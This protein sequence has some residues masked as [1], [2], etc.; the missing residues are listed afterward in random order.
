MINIKLAPS[1]LLL[2]IG[3]KEAQIY[4]LSKDKDEAIITIANLE[5]RCQ[6]LLKDRDMDQIEL[7]DLRSKVA[8]V[9]M[10][11]EKAH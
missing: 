11:V 4:Q 3:C 6:C 7:E 2:M 1:E 10:M 8:R 9:T 5:H